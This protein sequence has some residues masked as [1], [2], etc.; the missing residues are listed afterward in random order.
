MKYISKPEQATHA[1]LTITAAVRKELSDAGNN[2]SSVAS[3]PNPGKRMLSK[4]YNHLDSHHEARIPEAISHLYWFSD[5]YTSATFVN[6]NMKTLLYH[7]HHH[8][9]LHLAGLQSDCTENSDDAEN[10]M[11][12]SEVFDSE[13]LHTRHGYRLLSPFNDYLHRGEHLADMCLYD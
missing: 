9:Q 7:V 10:E 6:I 3:P 4:V 12:S 2:V 13:I 5:H 8:H 1:K 11:A